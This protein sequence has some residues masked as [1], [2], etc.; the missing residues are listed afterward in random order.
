M[1][2][3]NEKFLRTIKHLV[4]DF[5]DHFVF[6]LAMRKSKISKTKYIFKYVMKRDVLSHYLF[7]ICIDITSKKY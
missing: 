1:N 5:R 6:Y 3:G 4:N 2:T 7:M